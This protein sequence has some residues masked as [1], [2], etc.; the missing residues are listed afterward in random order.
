MTRKTKYVTVPDLPHCENR[1]L[2][3]TFLITEWP[4]AKAD[5]WV[6]RLAFAA[7]KGGGSL[8]LDLRGIGWEGVAIMGINTMLR[9][10]I[11]PDIMI[12]IGDELMECV[13]IVPDPKQLASVRTVNEIAG[14][15]E[16]VQTRWWLRDQ[17]VSVHTG[18]SFLDG[19]S[20][21]MSSILAWEPPT[22]GS[23]STQTPPQA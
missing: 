13:Q 6:Q 2:G 15:I 20:R 22:T 7:M 3:K 1:D 9:G 23:S 18:F 16:E 14:D 4:A 5:R 11:D 17:V 10:S 19:L 8:P 21:L 12:P